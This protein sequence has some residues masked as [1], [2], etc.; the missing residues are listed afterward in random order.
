MLKILKLSDGED[1]TEGMDWSDQVTQTGGDRRSKEV[2]MWRDKAYSQHCKHTHSD[3]AQSQ[4]MFKTD[5]EPR[6]VRPET[7]QELAP[8]F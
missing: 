4:Q 2:Y 7:D 1:A 5:L 6:A 8:T 3:I